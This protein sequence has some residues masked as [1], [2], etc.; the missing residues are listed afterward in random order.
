[1]YEANAAT[2]A[3]PQD[4]GYKEAWYEIAYLL[5]IGAQ[6]ASPKD[7]HANQVMPRLR[8]LRELEA[9]TPQDSVPAWA[10]ELVAEW[11]SEILRPTGIM[12]RTLKSCA[13]ELESRALALAQR[14]D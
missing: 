11:R 3:T 4:D 2:P 12:D 7:V 13:D 10:M 6:N 14:T 1:M 9:A 8:A 5:G